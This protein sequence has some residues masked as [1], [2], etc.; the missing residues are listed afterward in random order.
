MYYLHLHLTTFPLK[1]LLI[2]NKGYIANSVEFS[3][4]FGYF[5]LELEE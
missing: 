1:F 3:S 2:I 5:H 4:V